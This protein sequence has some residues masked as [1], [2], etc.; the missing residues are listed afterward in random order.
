MAGVAP[1]IGWVVHLRATLR[2]LGALGVLLMLAFLAAVVWLLVT[3][4]WIQFEQGSA[5]EW[6]VLTIVSIVLGVGMSWS[7]RARFACNES[8]FT[9]CLTLP[10]AGDERRPSRAG[11]S[12]GLL[13]PSTGTP[14]ACTRSGPR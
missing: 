12:I 5:I 9:C 8:S 10:D 11:R 1:L 14:P 4:N 13:D 6:V 2:S 3:W 7:R